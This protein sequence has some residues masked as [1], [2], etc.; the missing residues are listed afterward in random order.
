MAGRHETL[1]SGQDL[2]EISTELKLNGLSTQSALCIGTYALGLIQVQIKRLGKLQPKVLADEDPESLHQLRVGLRRLRTI[3]HQFMP[4]LALPESVDTDRIAAVARRTSLTRDLDV[5]GE[6]LERQLLPL[7]PADE[8]QGMEAAMKRLGRQRNQAFDLLVD[9]LRSPNYLKIL[10]R[11]HRWQDS[12]R[13][14][15]LGEQAID[16]W[17]YEL[18]AP[19]TGVL[20]LHRGWQ[21][22]DYRAEEL[23]SLRKLIKNA[24]YALENLEPWLDSKIQDGISQLRKTQ[25]ILGDLHDLGV[26]ELILADHKMPVKLKKLPALRAEIKRQQRQCWL[27][28]QRQV[29]ELQGRDFRNQFSYGLS[30]LT[31]KV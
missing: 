7:L 30:S 4:A 27:D 3:L 8:R 9:A 29:A 25:G 22:N 13:F 15:K 2:T 24:R 12:P 23:H 18:H 14:T 1:I 20:F 31:L 11:L 28:W 19:F 6:R 10:A 17:L 5:L 26:L 16:H 21:A